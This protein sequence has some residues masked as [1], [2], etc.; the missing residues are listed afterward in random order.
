M[1]ILS[2]Y[3]VMLRLD[4]SR[5]QL[6]ITDTILQVIACCLALG[7]FI[8]SV[9]GMNLKNH[10]EDD[11]HAFKVVVTLTSVGITALALLAILYFR[12]AGILPVEVSKRD[13]IFDSI[14]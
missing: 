4:T 13:T 11:K 8:G 5:N 1:H 7:S 3:Q 9:Y 14:V 2:K 12:A 6:L 10:I